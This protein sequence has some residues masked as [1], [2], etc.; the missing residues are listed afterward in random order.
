[1]YCATYALLS[2][3]PITNKAKVTYVPVNVPPGTPP[4]T[5]D[6]SSAKACSLLCSL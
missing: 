6:W 2:L 4:S 3:F 1:V 5:T